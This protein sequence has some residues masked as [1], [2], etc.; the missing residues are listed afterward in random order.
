MSKAYREPGTPFPQPPDSTPDFAALGQKRRRRM[1]AL[2]GAIALVVVGSAGAFSLLTTRAT[3]QA[4][5]SAVAELRA[6]LLAAPLEPGA[7]ASL[8]FRQLQLAG[9]RRPDAERLSA[10]VP[11]WP[12]TCR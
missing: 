9:M 1:L 3:H 12:R 5:E 11:I 7:S 2:S 4:T 8:R 10:Q 6:C